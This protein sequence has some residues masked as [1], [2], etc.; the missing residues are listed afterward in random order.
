MEPYPQN[1][2]EHSDLDANDQHQDPYVATLQRGAYWHQQL[3][4]Q[5]QSNLR[6][7]GNRAWTGME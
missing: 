6:S 4:R 1:L 3:R 7:R 2:L 5:V